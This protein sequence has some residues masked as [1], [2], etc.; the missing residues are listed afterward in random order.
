MK[1]IDEK[2]AIAQ[3]VNTLAEKYPDSPRAEIEQVVHDEHIRYDGRPIRAYVSVL[4][5][6]AAR[7]RLIA[8]HQH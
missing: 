6:R 4:V 2:G 5:Q 3:V 8:A 7:L 1:Q